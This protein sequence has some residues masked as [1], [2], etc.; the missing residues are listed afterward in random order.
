MHLELR[1]IKIQNIAFGEENVIRDHVLYLNK[2]SNWN[3]DQKADRQMRK[4]TFVCQ[5]FFIGDS[6]GTSYETIGT[7]CRRCAL[8]RR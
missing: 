4:N 6:E 7:A 1:K 5:L 2:E 8:A 3:K